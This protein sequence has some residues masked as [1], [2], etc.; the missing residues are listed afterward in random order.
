MQ[1]ATNL[2]QIEVTPDQDASFTV[3]NMFP[4]GNVSDI[5]ALTNLK[6]LTSAN[7]QFDDLYDIKPLAGKKLDVYTS[8]SYNHIT[9]ASPLESSKTSLGDSFTFAFQSYKLP[10]ITLNS[11]IKSY[12]MPSFVIKNVDG[13]NIPVRPYYAAGD[14]NNNFNNYAQAYKSTADGGL[15]SDPAKNQLT[16]T[17]LSQ[18]NTINHGYMTATWEDPLFGNPYF[19]YQGY[20][21]QPYQFSDAVGNVNVNFKNGDAGNYICQQETLSGNIDS[22]W[23][24]ALSGANSFNLADVSS[25]QNQNIQAIINQLKDRYGFNNISVSSPSS[26]TYSDSADVPSVTYTFSTKKEPEVAQPV[27][28]KYVDENNQSI[29]PDKTINGKVNDP[30]DASVSPYRVETLTNNNQTYQ[31]DTGKLPKNATGVLG[32]EPITVTYVYNKVATA[33][34]YTVKT[35]DKDGK[36]LGHGYTAK[37]KAGDVIKAP[38][39][40]GY[41]VRKPAQVTVDNDNQTITFVY[42]QNV[43]TAQPAITVKYQDANGI[44]LQSPT[45][46]KGDAG[47]DYTAPKAPAT[48]TYQGETY[49]YVGIKDNQTMPTKFGDHDQTFGYLYQKTSTGGGTG[50]GIITPTIPATPLTPAIPVTPATPIVP[51]TPVTPTGPNIAKKGE[52]VYS[53]KKIYLYR[54]VTFKK[55]QRLA[56]YVKKP[57]INRP[58]FVVTDYS[59]STNG[60]LRYKVRDVNHKSVTAGRTGYI[61]ANT[62][63]VLPVYY[64]N[65]YRTITVINPK[66]VNAYR[67]KNLTGKTNNYKQGTALKVKKIVD[68]NLTTRFVLTNGRYITANRKLVIAGKSKMAKMVKAK[69]TINVYRDVNLT[70]KARHYTKKA[71]KSFKVKRWEYSQA[72]RMNKKGALRYQ[73]AGGYITGNSKYLR[74][75][76]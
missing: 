6:D 21:I 49:K 27:S 58:M 44:D 52:V 2:K 69:G 28:V 9:D 32:S 16:W 7:F 63:Y 56:G 76:K 42:D 55:S 64:Q 37:G 31:L 3:W 46:S 26:G 57:R 1:Y 61:T 8:L 33:L 22:K 13:D 17:N 41:T 12:T 40:D 20:I 73:V 34:N 23:N 43:P 75:I 67:N 4:K 47:T 60:N 5:S 15:Y 68:H 70:K 24:L 45:V 71:K 62:K 54:N 19:T 53:V 38:D 11:N 65:K 72:N 51:A 74:V 14:S 39:I 36:D 48:L 10:T 50:G 25:T 30:Y 59:R 29:A 18:N 66:G 35:V